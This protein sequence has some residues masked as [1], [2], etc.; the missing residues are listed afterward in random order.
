M[1]SHLLCD[2]VK[3]RCGKKPPFPVGP[4]ELKEIF[5]DISDKNARSGQENLDRTEGAYEKSK[6]NGHQ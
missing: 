5:P 4:T 3:N 1:N 2:T 6:A